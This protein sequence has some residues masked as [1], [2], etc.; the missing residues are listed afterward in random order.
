MGRVV[1]EIIGQ[2]LD[3]GVARRDGSREGNGRYRA[4]ERVDTGSAELQKK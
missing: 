3:V 2:N 4:F 1:I